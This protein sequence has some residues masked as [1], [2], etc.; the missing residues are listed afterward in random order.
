MNVNTFYQLLPWVLPIVLGAFIG[1]L[2]NSVAIRMLFRPIREIRILG[3]RLPFTPGVIPRQRGELAQSIGRM[4]ARDL[5]TDDV[6]YKRFSDPGFRVGL[7][8]GISHGLRRLE[9]M[10]LGLVVQL[11]GAKQ[12]IKYASRWLVQALAGEPGEHIREHLSRWAAEGVAANADEIATLVS[13]LVENT[14]PLSPLTA[15]DIREVVEENWMIIVDQIESILERP[16]IQAELHQRVRRIIRYSMDQLTSMQ[17]LLVTAAQYDRQLEARIPVIVD[18]IVAE[19]LSAVQDRE[20][21]SR[22]IGMIED[23]IEEHRERTVG[24]LLTQ[25]TKGRMRGVVLRYL[26]D[27]ERVRADLEQQ[28]ARVVNRLNSGDSSDRLSRLISLWI[29]NHE[30]ETIGQ[31]M[32]IVRRRRSLISRFASVRIQRILSGLTRLFLE[33]LDVYTIVV[34]RINSL[35]VERVEALLMGII[36]RHLR[37]INLFGAILGSLI[38]AAQVALRL[39]GVV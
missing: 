20:N 36:R 35:D 5:L 4:V 37:W 15:D 14:R 28:F 3:V 18:R 24:S 17:R 1:Y 21:R 32:P 13:D 16:D 23:W 10:Q 34:D 31:L 29:E 11:I 6:F 26:G 39:L 25:E 19:V 9:A 12:A 27:G 7:Q 33:Q 8:R 30:R 2:T 38:G 22:I